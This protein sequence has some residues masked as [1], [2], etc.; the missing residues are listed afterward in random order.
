MTKDI[1]FEQS[2]ASGMDT[3]N[4]DSGAMA[5]A[6]TLSLFA[7]FMLLIKY[8]ETTWFGVYQFKLLGWDFFA[9]LMM[10]VFPVVAIKLSGRPFSELGLSRAQARD[11]EVRLIGRVAVVEICLIWAA[12]VLVPNLVNGARPH[13]LLPPYYFASYLDLPETLANLVGWAI[14]L[15]FAVIFC[16]VGEEVLFRG[17]I[18]GR[19]NRGLGRKFRL[20]GVTFGWGLIISSFLFGLGHGLGNYNP[21]SI[22][23]LNFHPDWTR[24]LITTAEGF[25]L[26][27]LY[28][29]TGGIFVP[30][31]VHATIGLFLG[32]IAF[33]A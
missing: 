4:M 16:G 26:G 5:I 27:L 32:S 23:P 11:R 19:L 13:L 12:V 25:I 30:C 28:E 7:I 2:N 1:Q 21:F 15:V 31:L 10:V 33:A 6:E 9:H 24:T 18:Q 14:T 29:R 17:Y 3:Q 8:L 20:M 22:H